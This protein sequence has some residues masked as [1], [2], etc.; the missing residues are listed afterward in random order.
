MGTLQSF[1][2][3]KSN[4]RLL[5]VLIVV[6]IILAL[7]L[8]PRGED[9]GRYEAMLARGEGKVCARQLAKALGRKPHWHEARELLIKAHLASDSPLL[10]LE[11]LLFLEKEGYDSRQTRAVQ[12]LLLTDSSILQQARK[13]VCQDIEENPDFD[14]ARIF[15]IQLETSP[16]NPAPD[17]DLAFAQLANLAK[18]G[19]ASATLEKRVINICTDTWRHLAFL[20]KFFC[21]GE[22]PWAFDMKL[23]DHDLVMDYLRQ[24]KGSGI[25][26]EGSSLDRVRNQERSLIQTLE[27]ALLLERQQWIDGVLTQ[28]EQAG[29]SPEELAALLELQPHEP[30]LLALQAFNAE[31]PR[32]GLETLVALEAA[33]YTPQ[34][35]QTYGEEKMSLIRRAEHSEPDWLNFIA[36]D[37]IMEQIMLW[38]D[39]RAASLVDWLEAARPDLTW[40]IDILR[41]IIAYTGKNP[42]PLWQSPE[43]YEEIELSPDGKWLLAK[44]ESGLSFIDVTTAKSYPGQRQWGPWHWSPDSKQ[45]ANVFPQ[46]G[47]TPLYLFSIDPVDGAIPKEMELPYDMPQDMLGWLDSSTLLLRNLSDNYETVA[48]VAID[49][50]TG[51]VRWETA[52]PQG[53]PMLSHN[54]ELAWVWR[55]RNKIWVELDAERKSFNLPATNCF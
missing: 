54:F 17:P 49:A 21:A 9:L 52:P 50:A 12:L 41:Q 31:D 48:V 37:L 34:D 46:Y 51:E 39:Q 47:T 29:L 36:N 20:D 13:L 44:S 28:A 6:G 18:K 30:R 5:G 40:E 25:E 16:N 45:V 38:Q 14:Y 8:L 27:L 35:L 23:R 19:L 26:L 7:L 33:G 42:K 55:E 43:R 22:S 10:A 1:L 15:L 2:A 3:N 32:Q 11:N 24:L 4:L 53:N